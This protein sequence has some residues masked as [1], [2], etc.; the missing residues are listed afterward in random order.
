MTKV[1]LIQT[2]RYFVPGNIIKW[3]HG[4]HRRLVDLSSSLKLENAVG[5]SGGGLGVFEDAPFLC[6]WDSHVH[7]GSSLLF[8]PHWEEM[9]LCYQLATAAPV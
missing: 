9:M 2:R 6:S 1:V 3:K 7:Q 4:A 8:V 5:V